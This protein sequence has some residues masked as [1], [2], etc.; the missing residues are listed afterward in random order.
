MADSL[1][2]SAPNASTWIL[3]V[4]RWVLWD[5]ALQGI[6][7]P[8]PIDLSFIDPMLRRR[9]SPLAK[10]TLKVA[11]DC[12]QDLPAV[13]FVYA[14]RHGEL[15]RTTSMLND[16][17]LGESIS[18]T[19]FSMS[20]LNSSPGL[21]SI[22]RRDMTP[23]TAISS[24]VESFGNGLLEAY[25]QMVENPS[26]PVLLVYAD[27]PAPDIYGN[28][29]PEDGSAHAIGLLL[30]NGAATNIACSRWSNHQALSN[31]SQSR[32][33]VRC[34][35]GALDNCWHGIDRTWAWERVASDC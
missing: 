22:L 2:H 20:V 34:L 6:G 11:H 1:L 14:S 12:A 7:S 26:I 32:S 21:F 23:S 9:L 10:M 15:T 5:A 18:P 17:A 28:M 33:F 31:E 19:A 13:R 8:S 4:A 24:S 30:R 16:L 25:I 29:E 27:E 35:E 3:P